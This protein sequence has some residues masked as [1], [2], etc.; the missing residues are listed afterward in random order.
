MNRRVLTILSLGHLAHDLQGGALPVLLPLVKAVFHLTYTQVTALVL[1]AN[2]SSS[3]IQPIF[4][5]WS[6]RISARWLIPVGILTTGLGIALVGV[7]PTYAIL[8][9]AVFLK[10]IG[11]AAFH[12]EGSRLA[13]TVSGDRRGAGMST[14]VVGGNLGLAFSPLVMGFVLGKLGLRGTVW[15][16][17]PAI[18]MAFA[19]WR[20]M[21]GV[22]QW[23]V[24]AKAR[25]GVVAGAAPIPRHILATVALVLCYVVLRSWIH[26]GLSSF[27]PLYAVNERGADPRQAGFLVT[28][29]LI[30]GAVG[31]ALGGP[32]SDRWGRTPLLTYSM[33]LVGAVLWLVPFAPGPWLVALIA[34]TGLMVIATFT[35]CVV[36]VQ[37]L[38]PGHIGLATGMTMGL[39]MGLGGVG[40]NILGVIADR[41]GLRAA[42]WTISALPALAFLLALRLPRRVST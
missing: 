37:E 21:Q 16:G 6:D 12:P 14:F 39:A 2:V 25:A 35:I 30:S 9:V 27:I 42:L 28:V 40:V 18:L 38:L 4:G 13:H 23:K 19:V 3:I 36:M 34:F 15:Y 22:P 29:L 1:V 10:G 5:V 33:L 41:W 20:A 8:I 11:Q 32:L 24:P 7:A 17:I 26:Q 31:T